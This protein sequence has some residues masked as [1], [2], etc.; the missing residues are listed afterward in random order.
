MPLTRSM[1]EVVSRDDMMSDLQADDTL[2]DMIY[3]CAHAAAA[4][5]A[6]VACSFNAYRFE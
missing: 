4:R 1:W 5:L 2:F 3:G 6:F